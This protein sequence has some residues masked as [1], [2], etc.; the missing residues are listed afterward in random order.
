MSLITVLTI[1]GFALLILMAAPTPTARA[2]PGGIALR[3]GHSTK[4]TLAADTDIEFWEKEVTPPGFD[5]GDSIDVTTMFDVRYLGKAPQPLI[6]VTDITCTVAYDPGVITS[7]KANTGL[8]TTITVTHPD[9]TT[10]AQF[11][12]LKSF[13]PQSHTRSEQ[14]TAEVTFVVTNRDRAASW[15]EAGPVLTNV[16]GT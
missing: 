16:A 5:S 2:T 6:D 12:Y 8:E 10:W 1:L 4:I 14:P 3:S 7:I 13:M 9:G 11:G 15:V